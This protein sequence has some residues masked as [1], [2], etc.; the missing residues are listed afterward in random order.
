MSDM[1]YEQ[2]EE[3][4]LP[5]TNHITNEG[6]SFETYG[7]EV[8][9]VASQ[10]NN[11]TWTELDGDNGV[12]LVAGY[13]YANRIQYYVTEVPWETD[14]ICI[15]I[16]EYVTCSCYNEETDEGD[17]DCDLCGGDGSYTDWK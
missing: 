8:D 5:I 10:D 6:S 14:D 3:K 9:F 2:W 7:D 1:T 15:T 4:Y 11:K 12:Y 16:C 13:H 17:V